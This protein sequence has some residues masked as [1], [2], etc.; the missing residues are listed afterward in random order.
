LRKIRIGTRGS[1]LALAQVKEAKSLLPE[2]DYEI[3]I[4]ETAGDRDKLSPADQVDFTGAIEAALLE[5]KIDLAVHSAKDLPDTVKDGL[6][7]FTMRSID[8]DDALVSK[9]NLKLAE[10]PK[11]AKIGTSSGRRREQAFLIRPDLQILDLRGNIDERL[12]KLDRGEYDAIIVAA[13]ALVRLRLDDRIA[14][15][16]DFETAKGQGSLAIQARKDDGEIKEWLE[17]FI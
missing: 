15:R 11:G 9:N 7:I 12:D 16:L 14:E 6:L 5:N 2:A 13:A 4:F 17:K 10:L 8:E 1:R 3:V